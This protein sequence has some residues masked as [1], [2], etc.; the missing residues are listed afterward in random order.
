MP[1]APSVQR[2][3]MTPGE[4][5]RPEAHLRL[6]NDLAKQVANALAILPVRVVR[7]FT[8]TAPDRWASVTLLNSWVD[9]P[10]FAS[11]AV[12]KDPFGFVNFRGA[13]KS[14]TYGASPIGTLPEGFRPAHT[15]SVIT[16]QSNATYTPPGV[17]SFLTTGDILAA[18]ITS[19]QVGVSTFL[20]FD[21]L[22]PFEAADSAA[23][24]ETPVLLTRLGLRKAATG[25]QVL[26][27]QDLTTGSPAAASIA[28]TPTGRDGIQITRVGGLTPGHRYTLRVEITSE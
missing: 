22:R 28:W 5:G 17:V 2:W 21:G 26:A 13:V 3:Q 25:A 4:Y 10:G 15:V 14:G 9:V 1:R 12:W 23:S 16:V 20:G 24:L 6:L 8:V 7:E 18:S 11:L 19:V 27:C